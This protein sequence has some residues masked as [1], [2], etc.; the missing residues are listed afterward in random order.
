MLEAHTPTVPLKIAATVVALVFV[1]VL[2]SLAIGV[3]SWRF[4]TMKLVDRLHD[5]RA[6]TSAAHYDASMLA[7]LPAPVARYF[8]AV[9]SDGQPLVRGACFTQT[10]TFRTG[11]GDDTW[12]PFNAVQTYGVT[13]PSFVWDARIHVMPGIAVNVC[14]AYVDEHA[15]MRGRVG[16][17]FKVVEAADTPDLESGALQRYLAEA[18]WYPTAL[19]PS[20][21]VRWTAI[22]EKRALATLTDGRTSVS[23]E[24]RFA[25]TGEIVSA[26]S[27]L[28]AR[29]VDGAYIGTP[30]ECHYSDYAVCDG[31]RIPYA[32]EVEWILPERRLPY[33]RGNITGVTFTF[34]P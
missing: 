11:D 24:F 2:M 6:T 17:L 25:P 29:E 31:L 5:S 8:R 34:A 14:D 3:W 9:L 22:D 27:P 7:E 4:A 23:L 13:P 20:E 26:Y 32:G 15:T 21:G 18:V 30:W 19:L 16:G 28:R 33:W 12:K 10:G 1:G